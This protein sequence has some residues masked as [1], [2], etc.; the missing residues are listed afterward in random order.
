M[1][2]IVFSTLFVKRTDVVTL[3]DELNGV[4]F[5]WFHTHILIAYPSVSS[6]GKVSL[7]ELDLI[8]YLQFRANKSI[9]T[10]FKQG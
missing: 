7:N 3:Y 4:E 6:L 2:Q 8:Y 5:L 1:I 10:C 9:I